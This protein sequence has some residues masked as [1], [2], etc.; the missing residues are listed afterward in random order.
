[1]PQ[2]SHAHQ[3]MG[4]MEPCTWSPSSR[5]KGEHAHR[6]NRQGGPEG[7][8]DGCPSVLCP[9]SAPRVHQGR[10]VSPSRRQGQAEHFGNASKS[11]KQR[12]CR[13]SH[14]PGRQRLTRS[15]SALFRE[16]LNV[17]AVN[18]DKLLGPTLL[19]SP[20]AIRIVTTFSIFPFPITLWSLVFLIS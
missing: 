2:Q 18:W 15:T 3:R 4:E 17:M 6:G 19:R 16:W 8:K 7:G 5:M 20:Q 10:L 11:F 9:L 1:M 14:G 13:R 12:L